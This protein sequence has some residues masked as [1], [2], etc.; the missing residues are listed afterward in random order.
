MSKATIQNPLTSFQCFTQ[1]DTEGI[2]VEMQGEQG[3]LVEIEFTNPISVEVFVNGVRWM[4]KL[5]AI[6]LEDGMQAAAEFCDELVNDSD[7]MTFTNEQL[8]EFLEE[9][10]E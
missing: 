1:G 2:L 3:E 7:E 6:M 10:N 8:Y 9:P 4:G 5:S